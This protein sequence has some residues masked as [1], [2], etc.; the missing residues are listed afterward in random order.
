MTEEKSIPQEYN[1]FE[2]NVIKQISKLQ[3]EIRLLKD[4]LGKILDEQN[5]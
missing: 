3:A 1:N 2:L 4:K 5:S